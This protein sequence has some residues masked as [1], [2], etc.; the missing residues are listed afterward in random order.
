MF[1]KDFGCFLRF[2]D[3]FN[4][5]FKVQFQLILGEIWKKSGSREACH[6][7]IWLVKKSLS[8]TL[9]AIIFSLFRGLFVNY[10]EEKA[11]IIMFPMR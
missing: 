8:A 1:L 2:L 11:R 10:I 5:F 6:C 3:V 9:A 7:F 4:E